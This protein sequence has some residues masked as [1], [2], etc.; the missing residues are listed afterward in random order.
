MT[1]IVDPDMGRA[2][3]GGYHQ[4]RIRVVAEPPDRPWT[5]VRTRAAVRQLL[6]GGPMTYDELGDWLGLDREQRERL[7]LAALT[8]LTRLGWI[9]CTPGPP[10]HERPYSW[11]LRRRGQVRP[12]PGGRNT[13]PDGLGIREWNTSGDAME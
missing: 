1:R 7:L 3:S 9:E 8:G 2:L 13:V 12:D 5:V 4:P 11:R 10:G 6:R